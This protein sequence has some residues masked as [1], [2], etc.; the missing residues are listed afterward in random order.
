LAG[1]RDGAAAMHSAATR[2]GHENVIRKMAR[3]MIESRLACAVAV[4]ENKGMRPRRSSFLTGRHRKGRGTIIDR[5]AATDAVSAIR[6]NRFA[7]YRPAGQ[8]HQRIRLWTQSYRP[9]GARLFKLPGPRR[10]AFP[11]I[12]RILFVI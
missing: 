7:D 9:L 2:L 5:S 1:K 6:R 8:K 12:R 10:T 4:L 11:F 3:L